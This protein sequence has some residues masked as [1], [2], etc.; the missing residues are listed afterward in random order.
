MS[1]VPRVMYFCCL[2]SDFGANVSRLLAMSMWSLLKN[3]TSHY[4]HHNEN[5]AKHVTMAI[6]SH[7]RLRSQ[8]GNFLRLGVSL[9]GIY[10]LLNLSQHYRTSV[11]TI[12]FN[13]YE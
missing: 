11:Y 13:P 6:Y 12:V 2:K 4:S 8:F 1:G 5:S 3:M 7:G 9:A 10:W